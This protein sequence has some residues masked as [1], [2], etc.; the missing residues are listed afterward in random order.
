[1][2]HVTTTATATI[3]TCSPGWTPDDFADAVASC[4][5]EVLS[6][7]YHLR[8]DGVEIFTIMEYRDE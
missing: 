5:A 7:D 2:V 3:I 4:P 1:M 8:E 6:F